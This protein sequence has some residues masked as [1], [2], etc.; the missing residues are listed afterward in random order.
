MAC[1]VSTR[2]NMPG[3]S[4]RCGLGNLAR[5]TTVPVVSLTLTSE[6]SMVPASG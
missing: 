6:N 3:S 4:S 5:S 2:T 1:G